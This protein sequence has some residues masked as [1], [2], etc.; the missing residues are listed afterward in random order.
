M[1]KDAVGKQMGGF[2][3]TRA[4]ARPYRVDT[5]LGKDLH[6]KTPSEV[7]HDPVH[8]AEEKYGAWLAG[9][10]GDE[11]KKEGAELKSTLLP[12]QQRVVDKIRKQP[13]LVV[14]HGTGSGK[15]F[16]SIGAAVDLGPQRAR[17]LVPAALRENYEKEIKKHVKG[18]LPIKVESIQKAVK[19]GNPPRGDL[20]IVD[21]AH[22][23]RNPQ[24]K[25][26]KL[27][28]QSKASKRML[29]TASPVYNMPEDVAPLVNIAAGGK[30][31]PEGTEFRKRFVQQPNKG[32]FALINPFAAKD[33]KIVHKKELGRVLNRW[34]DYH[35]NAEDGFPSISEERVNVKMTR[36]QSALHDQAWGQLPW[37][38]RMRL[39]KGL[40]PDHKDL[41]SINQFQAQTRQISSSEKKY[42]GDGDPGASPKIQSAVGRLKSEAGRN[43]RHKAVVYANYLSTLD[44]YSKE[45][46]DKGISH[47]SFR[48]DMKKKDRDQNVRDYNAG[49]V[50]A[51]LV[52]GAGGE[53]LDLKGT[54]QVQVLEPHWN[55]ER[56]RQVIGR[57]R[58]YKSH[59][60]LPPKERS[61]KVERYASRPRGFFGPKKG[62]EDVLYDTA[63][64]KQRLNDQVLGLMAQTGKGV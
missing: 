6:S 49:K 37:M 21:E 64:Q 43:P 39:G 44:D 63:S 51:L 42:S 15:T 32:F 41:A 13:G 30:A 2:M 54:R 56:L 25:G 48:G 61:V 7:L 16:S 62:V 1:E 17:V 4:G 47:T 58:R 57:A 35:G 52:S 27:L 50:K 18:S 20:L 60:H 31:L 9:G 59:D 24:S 23:V 11:F 3:Q 38:T 12:H 26:Y 28:R 29:L 40:P 22:R 36:R 5:L 46:T 19:D 53:G 55:E 14:A 10:E 34:V 8:D 45:L 33:P